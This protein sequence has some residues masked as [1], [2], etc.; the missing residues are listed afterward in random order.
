[1]S[2]ALHTPSVLLEEEAAIRAKVKD[3]LKAGRDAYVSGDWQK[4]LFEYTSVIT[5]DPRHTVALTNRAV[6]YLG[7]GEP[8]L[9]LQDALLAA[10]LAP[11]YLTAQIRLGQCNYACGFV[12][13]A[14]HH[15]E[16]ALSMDPEHAE[17]ASALDQLDEEV[18]GARAE[19][20]KVG[21]VKVREGK[22][23]SFFRLKGRSL[24]LHAKSLFWTHGDNREEG[25]GYIEGAVDL[26]D[27]VQI[28]LTGKTRFLVQYNQDS[29][30]LA[31]T[32]STRDE[33]N[34]WV[35]AIR[36]ATKTERSQHT[37]LP[38]LALSATVQQLDVSR[39]K[40]TSSGRFDMRSPSNGSHSKENSK[41]DLNRKDSH[42]RGGSV[43]TPSSNQRAHKRTASSFT[44]RRGS[45]RGSAEPQTGPRADP[46]SEEEPE[47]G[48]T[49]ERPR[50]VAGTDNNAE[51]DGVGSRIDKSTS[52]VIASRQH[53]IRGA[54]A[55][56]TSTAQGAYEDAGKSLRATQHVDQKEKALSPLPRIAP[57][58]MEVT[59]S[60]VRRHSRSTTIVL[61][62]QRSTHTSPAPSRQLSSA[63]QSPL[64]HS[65]IPEADEHSELRTR[66]GSIQSPTPPPPPPDAQGEVS[67]DSP[68]P[69]PP[70]S[71]PPEE[72]DKV[73]TKAPLSI[74]PP[75]SESKTVPVPE[76]SSTRAHHADRPDDDV[77]FLTKLLADPT[78]FCRFMSF[79]CTEYSEENLLFWKS[80]ET[81]RLLAAT[82]FNQEGV[83][84]D[85]LSC[86][87]SEG[88]KLPQSEDMEQ[89]VAKAL[90]ASPRRSRNRSPYPLSP[91]PPSPGTAKQQRTRHVLLEI[92]D[93]MVA[94]YLEYV[95]PNAE[96]QVT[97]P[98][99]MRRSLT[100]AISEVTGGQKDEQIEQQAALIGRACQIFV[101]AQNYV[102][103]IMAHD[104]VRRFKVHP[105]RDD[106]EMEFRPGQH[107]EPILPPNR[108]MDYFFVSGVSPQTGEKVKAALDSVAVKTAEERGREK[109][110]K[111]LP[112]SG[113]HSPLATLDFSASKSRTGL[114]PLGPP[115]ATFSLAF[116]PVQS[117]TPPPVSLSLSSHNTPSQRRFLTSK[118]EREQ[119]APPD[120]FAAYIQDCVKEMNAEK[121]L[122]RPGLV[123]RYPRHN[124]EDFPFD[125]SWAYFAYPQ[126][127]AYTLSTQER[128]LTSHPAV[129]T[130][131]DG[132][133]LFVVY[134]RYD[135]C[136]W[137]AT[138]P[139][140]WGAGG[141]EERGLL[142]EQ[143]GDGAEVKVYAPQAI[144][145]ISHY[146]QL[147]SMKMSLAGLHSIM[148][149]PNGQ[150]AQWAP[151]GQY[152]QQL[153]DY[154][155]MPIP[156]V[157]GVKLQVGPQ[158]VPFG[159]PPF[160]P[161]TK[162]N[163]PL[164]I[165]FNLLNVDRI[166]DVLRSILTE[167]RIIFTSASLSILTLA[168][169]LF[170]QILHPLSWWFPYIP[171]L[172]HT[173]LEA[174]QLPSPYILGI[175]A[176]D[177][178]LIE[179]ELRDVVV[180]ELDQGKVQ[181]YSVTLVPM[182]ATAKR[183]I[184]DGLR[185]AVR[186]DLRRKY[187]LVGQGS[188]A[189]SAGEVSSF[190][191]DVYQV[192]LHFYAFLLSG[193]RKFSFSVGNASFFNGA[194]FLKFKTDTDESA[195]S[196]YQK[197][198]GSRAFNMFLQEDTLGGVFHE[199]M[200]H[201]KRAPELLRD[202][203]RDA[204]DPL[205][206]FTLPTPGHPAAPAGASKT[207]SKTG[208]SS[209][210]DSSISAGSSSSSVLEAKH[211][212]PQRRK[213]GPK[214]A[215][216]S[217]EGTRR[218]VRVLSAV[219]LGSKSERTDVPRYPQ[220]ERK[221]RPSEAHL[222]VR[223]AWPGHFSS[224]GPS[225]SPELQPLP[226]QL[227]RLHTPVTQLLVGATPAPRNTPS[228]FQP[229]PAAACTVNGAFFPLGPEHFASSESTLSS[230]PALHTIL[231]TPLQKKHQR[232]RPAKKLPPKSPAN[233]PKERVKTL[234]SK[235]FASTELTVDE[236][237]ELATLLKHKR[238]RT[239][240]R[241]VLMDS[242][243]Q[244][245]S[246]V[247]LTE[248][249]HRELLLTL[250]AF[251]D[252]CE[253]ARDYTG[254]L[255]LLEC[256]DIFFTE[257]QYGAAQYVEQDL[258]THPIFTKSAYWMAALSDA[259]KRKG[260]EALQKGQPWGAAEK[261]AFIVGWM[262][263]AVHGMLRSGSSAA[264]VSDMVSDVVL[265]NR[266]SK[267]STKTLKAFLTQTIDALHEMGGD[268][269]DG[270]DSGLGMLR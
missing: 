177:L 247:C 117:G 22:A 103:L 211:L 64:S 9:G 212:T 192:V 86:P 190:D 78:D 216:V 76:I 249:A 222:L 3:H 97:L 122:G 43:F 32:C 266:L 28:E 159:L 233:Y 69:P 109:D 223:P 95:K 204:E 195:R 46:I 121:L 124:R 91:A 193:Y 240:M 167:Q 199:I 47:A 110:Q 171:T 24:E 259:V 198:V 242:K 173:T 176:E 201:G 246:L 250:S 194:G 25:Q 138:T 116:S 56:Q 258:I 5:Y 21:Q 120:S 226:E 88:A 146:A 90:F 151:F 99:Q 163:L 100:N 80:C 53:T 131:A 169:Q 210:G 41:K 234:M 29:T 270:L 63:R 129:M 203:L 135:V 188:V 155:P 205:K 2:G 142:Y 166:C 220:S 16:N 74:K 93:E 17:A 162:S 8:Q 108:M 33:R 123:D 71:P 164:D 149:L 202:L 42:R 75:S 187:D 102:L 237:K 207:E 218:E 11:E 62:L 148:T 152:L 153:L 145:L 73:E 45:R 184:A 19:A 15:Y 130:L 141:N 39:V 183:I 136:L 191:L 113:R 143:S 66:A 180:V 59:Y 105:L 256:C 72:E 144:A 14:R 23:A 12:A 96:N 26:K 236:R 147:R 89:K 126:K 35:I 52:T 228:G 114:A 27:I 140:N 84:P 31:V 107:T 253:H 232:K 94:I 127:D 263:P 225:K 7:L 44:F 213:K 119:Q 55:E 158:Q 92:R 81:L 235:T 50:A 269:I 13:T 241:N 65:T 189:Q 139:E 79:L 4:A 132:T 133:Q 82:H 254:G 196:F 58:Y 251:L 40:P 170:L 243:Q 181:Y 161:P 156:G 174:H 172:G 257:D 227:G 264:Q 248:T 230:P 182:P 1:M 48:Y 54:E 128:P 255:A 244:A 83:A 61:G 85:P 215:L 104:S 150:I 208:S 30:N 267:N 77:A 6:T 185:E 18:A 98:D 221:T 67:P 10:E 268:N 57:A 217:P 106:V 219:R 265:E 179:P 87:Q 20:I 214:M 165:L 34:E 125:L 200:H 245:Q 157:I 51:G 224:G 209:S 239:A 178:P 160:M 70:D 175:L 60:P 118:A 229:A 168:T 38:P 49:E 115:S 134:F 231:E 197:F 238:V 36:D 68:I 186:R 261:D 112:R 111:A 37:E 137:R 154:L 260:Q 206:Y 262:I 252:S 101:E